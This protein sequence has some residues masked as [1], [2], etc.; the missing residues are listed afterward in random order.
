MVYA[1]KTCDR[2]LQLRRKEREMSEL[3]RDDIIRGLLKNDS[4][5][6]EDQDIIRDAIALINELPEENER[7]S[8]Y[9]ITCQTPSGEQT[10]P[11]LLSLDGDAATLYK[12]IEDKI[13]ADTVREM[14]ERIKAYFGTYVL[15]YKIPLNEA[16]KAVNQ[17]TKEMLEGKG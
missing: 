4:P 3:N 5:Y 13:K 15:G 16:L 14:K 9:T 10:M 11:N 7:L 12:K 8:K 2:L 6:K 1:L 17:I